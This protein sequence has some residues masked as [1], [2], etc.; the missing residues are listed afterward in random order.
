MKTKRSVSIAFLMPKILL[1]LCYFVNAMISEWS[2][3][4]CEPVWFSDMNLLTL[5]TVIWMNLS[6]YVLTNFLV[7]MK[8]IDTIIISSNY[9]TMCNF[10]LLSYAFYYL[11]IVLYIFGKVLLECNG[12]EIDGPKRM[13]LNFFCLGSLGL[14]IEL[15]EFI[16]IIRTPIKAIQKYSFRKL[17]S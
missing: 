9:N 2:Y 4:F 8:P 16:K 17:S 12:W 13:A 11:S 15:N 5:S 1:I 3:D 10:S 14:I 6:A 7:Y